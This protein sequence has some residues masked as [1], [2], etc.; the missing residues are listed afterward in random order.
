MCG[1][2]SSRCENDV[3]FWDGESWFNIGHLGWRFIKMKNGCS[4]GFIG[5]LWL[6][7]VKI[8]LWRIRIGFTCLLFG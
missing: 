8:G 4:M 1:F 5:G 2:C 3:F 7:V 6:V